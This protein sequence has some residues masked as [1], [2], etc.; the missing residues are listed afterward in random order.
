MD[1]VPSDYLDGVALMSPSD[2]GKIAWLRRPGFGWEGPFIVVD[3]AQWDDI[4]PI[5]VYR[6]EVVE[7]GW[8]TKQRWGITEPLN[9]VEVVVTSNSDPRMLWLALEWSDSPVYY[10]DWWQ[11]ILPPND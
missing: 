10:P 11:S 2:I 6:K 8:D 1:G 3:C 7:V 4:W 9:G 5:V